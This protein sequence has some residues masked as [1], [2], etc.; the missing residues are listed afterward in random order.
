MNVLGV[1]PIELLIITLVAFLF[2]GPGRMVEAARSL[3]KVVREIKRTTGDL[4]SLVGLDEPLDQ[5]LGNEARTRTGEAVSGTR[6][7]EADDR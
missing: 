6:E 2:L 1:G 7:V 5:P 3:G 4:P